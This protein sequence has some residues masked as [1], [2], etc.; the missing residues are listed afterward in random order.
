AFLGLGVMYHRGGNYP[1]AGAVVGRALRAARRRRLRP[2]EGDAH[3]ELFV[4]ALDAHRMR[5][6]YSHARAAMEAYGIH[7]PRFPH[8]AHDVGCFWTQQGRFELARPIFEQ[9]LPCFDDDNVR[10]RVLANLARATAALGERERYESSRRAAMELLPDTPAFTAE[11]L[12]LLS[13]GDL[14][15]G[16]WELASETARAAMEIA[17]ERGESH[18]RL[19]AEAHLNRA[20]SRVNAADPVPAESGVVARQ[21]E[22]LSD[23]LRRS[24]AKRQEV[25]AG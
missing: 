14:S 24:L 20:R 5:E 13:H 15:A 17:V 22:R 25:L 7:H 4:F 3:H 1:A 12:L 16:E 19:M 10:V 23:E 11:V 8:L 21:A 9:L 18:T 2:L 6:A